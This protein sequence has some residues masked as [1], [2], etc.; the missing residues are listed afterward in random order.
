MSDTRNINITDSIARVISIIF[1]PVLM[2]L[3]G[4]AILFTAPT[5]LEYLPA[6]VKKL[7]LLIV[8]V[9]NVL[10][11]IALMPIF[12]NRNIIS[13]YNLEERTERIIPLV[14]TTILYGASSFIIYR[15]Q[16]PSL[17]KYFIYS[18]SVLIMVVTIL[19]FRWK[20]SIH[21]AGAG[22][23]IAVVIVLGIKMLTPLTGYLVGAV[24][25]AGLVLASRLRLNSHTPAQ[26]WTGL[27]T[28][29]AGLILPLMLF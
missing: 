23:L 25:I 22:A 9:N 16:I 5:F 11:P 13:S 27:L 15:Y 17:I 8:L 2:P 19:N 7:L 6:T 21:A 4:L 18:A 28:G 24:V 1:H 12:R 26:V 29:F 20:L 14:T 10:V 3:Y